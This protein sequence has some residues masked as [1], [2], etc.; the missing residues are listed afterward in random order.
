MHHRK[1]NKAWDTGGMQGKERQRKQTVFAQSCL[2]P[3]E[4]IPA[5]VCDTFPEV[6]M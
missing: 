1:G 5:T 2:V 3:T 6:S 4:S